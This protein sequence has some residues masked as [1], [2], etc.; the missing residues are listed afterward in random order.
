MSKWAKER[1]SYYAYQGKY[2]EYNQQQR[3]YE[4]QQK[5]AEEGY[6]YSGVTQ[7]KWWN[8]KCRQNVNNYQLYNENGEMDERA[9]EQM[10][11][12]SMMPGWFFFF[13]GKLEEDDRQREEMGY[14][15][16]QGNMIFVY[17]WTV[18][19]FIGLAIFGW[20]TLY[21]GRDRM[22]LIIAL[23]IFCQFALLNLITTVG[24]IESDDRFFED[25]TY[26]WFGQISVLLAYT[27]FWMMIQTFAFAVLLL[28]TR[29]VDKRRGATQEEIQMGYRGAD[30][31]AIRDIS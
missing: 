1:N 2:N 12:R 5:A 19:I 10:Q 7:C 28:I 15:Q 31:A 16:S 27:D 21:K 30:E 17:L 4:E 23:S 11:M 9:Y 8:F 24:A 20:I 18:F 22:G 6:Y 26:G 13:G 3:Q 25:S 14:G 29:C